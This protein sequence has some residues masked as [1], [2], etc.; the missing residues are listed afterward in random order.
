MSWNLTEAKSYEYEFKVNG[1]SATKAGSDG[2]EFPSRRLTVG[3]YAWEIRY[4]PR[5]HAVG[6]FWV[7]FKLV[8]LGPA[9]AAPEDLAGGGSGGGGVVK[10]SPRCLLVDLRISGM[11]AEW[12]DASGKIRVCQEKCLPYR[13]LDRQR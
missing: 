13:V 10:V 8:F 5:C 1:Y 6:E 7:A 12:R 9:A 4:T 3:G 11:C 2:G